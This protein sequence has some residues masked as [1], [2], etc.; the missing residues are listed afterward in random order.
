[1]SL[2]TVFRRVYHHRGIIIVIIIHL[3][4]DGP[5]EYFVAHAP[6]ETIT[7]P[8]RHIAVQYKHIYISCPARIVGEM[9]GGCGKGVP[10]ILSDRVEMSQTTTKNH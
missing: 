6:R 8:E 2:H 10:I 9:E 1:M 5:A 7:G 3:V 4:R